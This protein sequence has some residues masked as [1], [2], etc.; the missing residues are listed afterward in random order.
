M[1][2]SAEQWRK[3]P[4]SGYEASS[5]GRVRRARDGKLL[6]LQKIRGYYAVRMMF[7]DKTYTA[8][9]H[10]LVCLA[11]LGLKPTGAECTRHLNG[12]KL[13]NSPKNLRWGT[14]KENARD[15]IL[16]GRQVAGFDHPNVT[17]KREEARAIRAQYLQH[18]RGR[19]QK[20]AKNGFIIHLVTQFPHLGYKC[21]Y[22]ACRGRYDNFL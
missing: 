19:K 9:A 21:V 11:F 2:F 13:D 5:S 1:E 15:T 6:K 8:Y 12:N 10:R 4:N 22:K 14:N 18:M 20:H 17:I 7:L 3:I 16:H